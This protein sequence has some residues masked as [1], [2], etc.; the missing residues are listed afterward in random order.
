MV[1]TTVYLPEALAHGIRRLAE[2]DGRPAAD[3]IREALQN[4]LD[5]SAASSSIPEWVGRYDSGRSDVSTNA[6]EILAEA[7]SRRR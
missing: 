6:E 1:K 7:A 5:R 3:L 4:Y 2:A